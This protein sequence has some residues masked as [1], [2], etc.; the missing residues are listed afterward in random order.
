M[1]QCLTERLTVIR[2][3]SLCIQHSLRPTVSGTDFHTSLSPVQTP[4][5]RL[6]N[7][8]KER[9][10]LTRHEIIHYHTDRYRPE[11]KHTQMRTHTYKTLQAIYAAAESSIL[12]ANPVMAG[13]S[14]QGQTHLREITVAGF[15]LVDLWHAA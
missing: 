2:L 9:L 13:S 7:W 10:Q 11:D 14:L 6:G 3:A 5:N 8:I 1:I 12:L 4:E 15:M